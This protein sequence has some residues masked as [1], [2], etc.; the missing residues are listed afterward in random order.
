[1]LLTERGPLMIVYC[2]VLVWLTTVSMLHLGRASRIS[3]GRATAKLA[4]RLLLQSAPIMLLLFLLF[5]RLPQPL[6]ALQTDSASATSGLSE[7]MSPGDISSLKL[8]D[9]IAFRV[10]FD[11][12]VP[13][14]RDLYWRGPVMSAFNGRTWRMAPPPRRAAPEA[15]IE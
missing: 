3:N 14:D 15:T 10:E 12:R 9:A 13:R 1:S 4:S 2:F 7:Q 11:G 5:P 8:S 6:W